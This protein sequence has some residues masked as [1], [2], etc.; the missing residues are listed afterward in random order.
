MIAPTVL[1]VINLALLLGVIRRLDALNVTAPTGQDELPLPSP[2]TKIQ[3]FDAVTTT[4]EVVRTADLTGRTLVAFFAEG[5]SVCAELIPAFTRYAAALPRDRVLVVAMMWSADG[6]GYRDLDDIAR[7]VIESPGGPVA[8]AFG[9]DGFPA[10]F[11]LA[12]NVVL[13]ASA[14]LEA[15]GDFH[16]ARSASV[17]ESRAAR[18]AG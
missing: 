7:V 5:C 6:H 9:V 16:M 8:A 11:Q 12:D 14:K 1:L 2:G 18:N 3:A 4:G 10:F 15:L 13:A 17:G